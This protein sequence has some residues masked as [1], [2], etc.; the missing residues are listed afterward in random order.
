L[1]SNKIPFFYYIRTRDW[2]GGERRGLEWTGMNWT[3]EE[4]IGEEWNL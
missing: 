4:G 3:G 1:K 2:K